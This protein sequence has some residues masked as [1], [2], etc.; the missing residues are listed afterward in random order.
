LFG[1]LNPHHGCI[2]LTPAENIIP[3]PFE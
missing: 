2:V 3:H 1:S